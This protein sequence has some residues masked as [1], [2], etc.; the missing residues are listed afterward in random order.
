MRLPA[1]PTLVAD[2][3]LRGGTKVIEIGCGG[4]AMTSWI[5]EVEGTSILRCVRSCLRPACPQA[6]ARLEKSAA[7]LP[8]GSSEVRPMALQAGLLTVAEA[9]LRAPQAD[10][11]V[12]DA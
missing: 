1:Q 6:R 10:G 4:G 2:V 12:F 5:A 9:C 3:G 8:L 11:W 7:M